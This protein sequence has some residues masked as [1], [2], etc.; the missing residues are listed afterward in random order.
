MNN[1][2]KRNRYFF[3]LG[4]VG[5]DMLYSMV[6]M[7]LMIYLTE[8]LNLPDSTMWGMTGALTV[9]RIFDAVNDPFMGFLV[10]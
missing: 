10:D 5:R 4:T 2:S 8:V 7:Y 6:S 9:L 3:G 1:H